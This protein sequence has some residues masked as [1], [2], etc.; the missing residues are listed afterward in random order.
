[1][2]DMKKILNTNWFWIIF[3]IVMGL[4]LEFTTSLDVVFLL[5]MIGV[6][7]GTVFYHECGHWFFAKVRKMELFMISSFVGMYMNGRWYFAIPAYISWGVCGMYKPL[8]NG[9]MTKSDAMWYIAG[10]MIFNLAAVVILIGIKYTL[11]IENEILNFLI[12][13]NGLIMITT[14]IPTKNNDGGRLLSL[15]RGKLDE[16]EVFESANYL[17][18]V[19]ISPEK[20]QEDITLDNENDYMASY[21][22]NLAFIELNSADRKNFEKIYSTELKERHAINQ[23]LILALQ[24]MY[25]YSDGQE[26]ETSEIELFNRQ[27]SVYSIPFNKLYEFFKTGEIEHLKYFNKHR[28]HFPMERENTVFM[29]ALEEF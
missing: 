9:R 1:M 19:D 11:N 26:L 27:A 5:S 6:W 8:N 29:R 2:D 10:G 4:M 24:A 15:L 22:R 17:C 25:K 18:D 14:A 7:A 28:S 23:P 20:I 3:I 21:A 13:M 16:L 12:L